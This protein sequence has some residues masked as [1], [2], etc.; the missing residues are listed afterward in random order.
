MVQ[1]TVPGAAAP[2][3]AVHFGSK[4]ARS[5]RALQ[6]RETPPARIALIRPP[7]L[8]F[9]ASFS[10]FGAVPP[11][12]LAYVAAV[13]RDAGHKITVIDAPVEALERFISVPS[14]AGT[15]QLNGLTVEEVID[16]LD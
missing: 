11:I 10:S 9:P 16:R 8:Q 12:G 7:I 5:G 6:G 4:A 2:E 3:L 14:P 1:G 15:L 13:L